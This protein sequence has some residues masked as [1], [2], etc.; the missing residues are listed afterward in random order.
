MWCEKIVCVLIVRNGMVGSDIYSGVV[1]L[2]FCF[3]SNDL[4]YFKEDCVN[5]KLVYFCW[6]CDYMIVVIE[7]CVYRCMIFY[8]VLEIIVVIYDVW[9]DLM[10]LCFKDV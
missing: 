5:K 8:F 3:N 7:N 2:R 1:L 9:M 6:N 10:L 4:L